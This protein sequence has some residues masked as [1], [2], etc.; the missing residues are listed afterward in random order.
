MNGRPTI[1]HTLPRSFEKII[2]ESEY[3]GTF[4]VGRSNPPYLIVNAR[5]HIASLVGMNGGVINDALA[6]INRSDPC[7]SEW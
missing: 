3:E 5:L 7:K 4:K 1:A 6:P 2:L